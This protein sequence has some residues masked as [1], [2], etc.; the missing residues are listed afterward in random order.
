MK[1]QPFYV[2]AL[3]L[4]LIALVACAAPT[5]VPPTPTAIPP[6]ATPVPTPDPTAVIKSLVDALNAGNVDASMAF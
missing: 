2:G 4:A 1:K 3:V 5:P 6:T